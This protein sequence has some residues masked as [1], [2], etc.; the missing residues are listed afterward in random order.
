ME[1][2][3]MEDY[4]K[5]RLEAIRQ[6]WDSKAD[7]WDS[8]LAAEG[9]HLNEDAAYHRF[10]DAAD[11]VVAARESFCRSRLLVD[12]ACGTGLVL[13]H[14]IDRFERTVGVDVSPRMLAV[15]A[16]RQLPRTEL[17]QASCFE[18]AGRVVS[19][20]AVLSRGILLSHYGHAAVAP[21]LEQVRKV[22]VPDGGFAILDFLN[23]QT[24]YDYPV[25][26]D[27]KT[28]YT[29]EQILAQAKEAGFRQASILGEPNR[30]VL[31][32]LAQ[33]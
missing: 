21:L 4:D 5:V 31:M 30:R 1:P 8:E 20:G 33:R 6:R 10:L 15:A 23:A 7:R 26:P 28:Y 11:A 12:L 27:N 19:A 14:F 25:N 29:G 22:L 3:R 2:S 32:L 24:R 9:C 13:A 17:Q 18:L 16:A